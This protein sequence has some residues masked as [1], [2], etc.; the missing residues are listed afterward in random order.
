MMRQGWLLLS[1]AL[2]SAACGGGGG[3]DME[4]SYDPAPERA[5]PTRPAAAGIEGMYEL[6]GVN[7]AELP[8]A[9]QERDG[10]R[11]EVLEGALRMEAERFAF[12]NRT[13]EV[14]R[15]GGSPEPVLHSAGGTY[16]VRDRNVILRADVGEA[17]TEARG[18]ADE[19]TVTLERL[20]T[21]AG[22][23]NVTWQFERRDRQLVPLE[24]E[25]GGR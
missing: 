1:G 15:D 23:E 24:G 16:E 10:C 7:G 19:T 5:G 22:S 25:T 11:V 18:T 3:E 2:L 12:Q 9:V 13:R 14:C 4:P 8:A 21:E 6:T 20:S 17:F